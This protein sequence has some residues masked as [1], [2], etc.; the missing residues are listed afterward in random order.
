MSV[1]CEGF[2]L[3]GRGLCGGPITRPEKSYRMLCITDI[4]KPRR[5]GGPGPLGSVATWGLKNVP[6]VHKH[7]L[8]TATKKWVI[9][10]HGF[11]DHLYQAVVH[12]EIAE[13]QPGLKL[14]R[15]TH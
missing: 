14:K 4:V 6:L 7:I 8:C 10:Y 1:C 9:C 2:V 15:S 3:S 13:Q 5:L 11:P 12:L